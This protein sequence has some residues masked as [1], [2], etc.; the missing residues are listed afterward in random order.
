MCSKKCVQIRDRGQ[1]YVKNLHLKIGQYKLLIRCLTGQNTQTICKKLLTWPKQSTRVV[2]IPACANIP[3]GTRDA[4]GGGG[5]V[6]VSRLL[7]ILPR[8]TLWGCHIATLCRI[9]TT[10]QVRGLTK[11]YSC[12]YRLPSPLHLPLRPLANKN[13]FYSQTIFFKAYLSALQ[14]CNTL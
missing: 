3:Q 9:A 13:I 11:L 5:W 8:L 10:C 14:L 6:C 7:A 12:Q 4:G 1:T 2:T